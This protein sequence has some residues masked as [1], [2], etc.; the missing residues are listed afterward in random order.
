MAA[1]SGLDRLAAEKGFILVYPVARKAMWATM[2]IDPK[3]LD[4]I[5]DV[6]FF[7]QLLGHLG[8]RFRLD[9]NRIYVVGM[10]NGASFAQLVAFVRPE[11]AAVVAHSGMKPDELTHAIRPFPILLLVGG[12]DPAVNAIRSDAA[13][14]RDDGH[15]VELIVVSGLGHQWSTSHNG[16]MWD[17]LSK[18]A[19][20]RQAARPKPTGR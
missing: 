15:A 13:Q 11:V 4:R 3:N 8:E 1:Y 5:P 18:H 16:A 12:D 2:N 10:S 19:R 14:Y 9:P 6:R 7:G 20:D 17:F